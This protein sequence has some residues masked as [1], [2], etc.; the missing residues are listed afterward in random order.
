MIVLGACLTLV[1]VIYACL[2][3]GSD[4]DD[5]NEIMYQKWISE[6]K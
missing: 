3:I 2:K 1:L 4:A 5:K 6:H